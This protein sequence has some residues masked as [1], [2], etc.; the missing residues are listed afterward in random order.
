VSK[1]EFAE[2]FDMGKTLLK[3]NPDKPD[4]VKEKSFKYNPYK[5]DLNVSLVPQKMDSKE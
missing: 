4:M 2:L 5:G 3:N 1:D